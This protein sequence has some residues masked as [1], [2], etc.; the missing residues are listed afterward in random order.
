MAALYNFEI[1]CPNCKTRFTIEEVLT[2][3]LRSEFELHMKNQL[4]SELR[5]VR[6]NEF[7]KI[8][9]EHQLE[10][11]NLRKSFESKLQLE[12]KKSRSNLNNLLQQLNELRKEL[13]ERKK[14]LDEARKVELEFRKRENEIL[15]R[16]QNLELEVQRRLS[17]ERMQLQE[18]VK[19]SIHS[20]YELKLREREETISSLQKK[21]E[22]LN[23][24]LQLGSQQ[25]QGEVQE[26]ALEEQLRVKFP[27][28]LIEPVPK[29]IRGAD[30]VQHVMDKIGQKCGTILWE[31]KRTNN[32]SND[33]IPKLKEDQREIGAEFS[34]IVSRALPKEINSVGLV[35]GVWVASYESYIGLAMALRE[36]LIQVNNIK[37]SL[38]GRETKMEQVYNYICSEQFLQK[39]K[40]IVEAFDSMKKDLEKE[41][42]SLERH[43]RKREEELNKVLKNAARIHGELAA[44][45][46]NQLPEIEYFQLP[47]S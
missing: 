45:V 20:E 17:Q 19:Q 43:W 6:E 41:K 30:I 28:D 32:W 26:I 11:E 47:G 46:G 22:E 2:G 34:V 4:E 35:D 23:F 5:R 16:E 39:I 3:K 37:N 15:Q 31:S 1:E 42:A 40:A 13:E 25:L 9:L 29:G 7:R 27:L 44:I 36:N 33:W 10:I 14:E 8:Q 21:V 24:K 18:L 12:L 38:M